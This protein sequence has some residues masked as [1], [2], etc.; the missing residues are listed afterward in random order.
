MIEIKVPVLLQKT[1]ILFRQRKISFEFLLIWKIYFNEMTQ[2]RCMLFTNY[3][4]H[5]PSASL[6][7]NYSPFSQLIQTFHFMIWQYLFLHHLCVIIYTKHIS[8][9]NALH[10]CSY[11]IVLQQSFDATD[12]Y[13]YL[14]HFRIW[15]DKREPYR[16]HNL[17]PIHF[18]YKHFVIIPSNPSTS[19][20][21]DV[22]N[23]GDTY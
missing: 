16:M 14:K 19:S 20:I 4:F 22:C 10:F 11:K 21:L 18:L 12:Y 3:S 15:K 6:A 23:I 5:F 7:P 9:M 17:S 13:S 2:V 1:H 8:L